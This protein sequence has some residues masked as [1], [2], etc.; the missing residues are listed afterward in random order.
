MGDWLGD[1]VG[2][3]GADASATHASV[4]PTPAF[5]FTENDNASCRIVGV[6]GL[7]QFV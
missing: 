4:E 5:P 3:I 6:I 2:G 1:L 7:L